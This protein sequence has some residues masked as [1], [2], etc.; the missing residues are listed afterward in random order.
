MSCRKDRHTSVALFG[1]GC[2]TKS[3]KRTREEIWDPLHDPLHLCHA[4]LGE[5]DRRRRDF[6]EADEMRLVAS[7]SV[8]QWF[9]NVFFMESQ[10]GARCLRLPQRRDLLFYCSYT[11]QKVIWELYYIQSSLFWCE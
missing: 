3:F 6:V 5:P 11:P 7:G 2:P 10:L 8:V 9:A 1:E 4:L